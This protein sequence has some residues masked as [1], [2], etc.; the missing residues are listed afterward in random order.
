MKVSKVYVHPTE[1]CSVKDLRGHTIWYDGNAIRNIVIQNTKGTYEDEVELS[2]WQ[3][4]GIDEDGSY[5]ITR[6]DDNGN[7]FIPTC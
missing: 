7:P 5:L 1:L 2:P 4:I 3:T 6:F